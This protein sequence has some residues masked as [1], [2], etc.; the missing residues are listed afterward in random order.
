MDK[1]EYRVKTEQLLEYTEKKQ[2]R[3]AMEIAENIC[4]KTSCQVYK[5]L[6]EIHDN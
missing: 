5:K 1:Y 3:K 6:N 2:Y 4:W